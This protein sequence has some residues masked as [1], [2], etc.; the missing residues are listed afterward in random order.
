MINWPDFAIESESS[1][2]TFF[3]DVSKVVISGLCLLFRALSTFEHADY[4]SFVSAL[5][6][7][8]LG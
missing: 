7:A 3:D 6:D 4:D 1:L 5:A 2:L 8:S